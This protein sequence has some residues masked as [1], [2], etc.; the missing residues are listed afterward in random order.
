MADE[1]FRVHG[2][3]VD[4]ETGKGIPD[5]RVQALAE[6]LRPDDRLGVAITDAD[7]GFELVYERADFRQIYTDRKA[8]LYL[9]V[10]TADEETVFSSSDTVR[11]DSGV[12]MPFRI[13][14]PPAV[15]RKKVRGGE[16]RGGITVTVFNHR[17]RPLPKARVTLR[18]L[19]GREEDEI[20]LPYDPARRHF[21]APA[22][23]PGRYYLRAAAGNNDPDERE[24]VVG[25]NAQ[26]QTFVLGP[27]GLPILYR[28]KVR[29]PVKLPEDL[30][31][32]TLD[33]PKTDLRLLEEADRLSLK[34]VKIS[35]AIRRENVRVFRLRRGVSRTAR[36]TAQ[37]SLA[38]IPGVRLVG[39]VIK[40]T[41]RGVSYLTNELVVSFKS[42]VPDE[43][44]AAEFLADF[45]LI[46]VRTIPYANAFLARS[47]H[48]ADYELLEISKRIV[49]TGHVEYAEPH[50][51]IT[52][53]DHQVNPTDYQYPAQWTHA[54][55][56]LPAAWKLLET[57]LGA[58][59]TF[60]SPDVVIAVMDHGI[61]S[62]TVGGVA[63]AVHPDFSGTVSDG[64]SKVLTFF[65]FNNM[66][67][68]ND[69][70]D[71]MHGMGCAGIAA[72][73]PNNASPV[74]G[75]DEGIAGAAANCRVMAL[76]RPMGS[77]EVQ[78]ADAYAWAA[79]LDPG[80]TSHRGRYQPGT[81]FP[82]P[83][84][85][86]AD[87]I[88]SSF[89]TPHG[90]PINGLMDA[91]LIRLTSSGRGGHGCCLFFS[92][93]NDASAMDNQH[94]WASHASTMAVTAST[95]DATGK[96]VRPGYSNFG[97]AV[98]FCAPSSSS[99]GADRHNPP[100]AYG[101]ISTDFVGKGDLIGHPVTRTTLAAPSP[102]PVPRSNAVLTVVSAMGFTKQQRLQIRPPGTAGAESARVTH[103]DTVANKITVAELLN[104]HG[105]GTAV[106]TGPRDY[107]ANFGSTS[108]AAPL[109]AGVAALMLSV[110]PGLSWKRVRWI[111]KTT[112][113]HIDHT[114]LN[115][116]GKWIDTDGDGIVDHSQWYGC[117]RIDAAAAVQAAINRLGLPPV[118]GLDT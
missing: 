111:L 75:I 84:A 12:T 28:G 38:E 95:L 77:E 2:T 66:V 55:I 27:R 116:D 11:Y 118:P 22:P 53:E 50:L 105:F 54:L 112:A 52:M 74:A 83:P 69:A 117:G 58:S 68:N 61:Q 29:V 32:L 34:Q 59:R 42:S 64:T 49:D 31:A 96:E 1:R 65:D 114:Q 15:A 35:A 102:G 107:T 21:H 36:L 8:D 41:R 81:V 70:A 48:P 100:A 92:A 60:G 62:T 6:N 85:K 63:T 73:L 93:G 109:A 97:D 80:W 94:P 106:A 87:I 115:V 91:T 16:G 14:L 47:A 30:V 72:A 67:K 43:H 19:G 71:Y 110:N 90:F 101:A 3:I 113:E 9:R 108:A 4:R 44:A 37:Q 103:V 33:G 23:R 104:L 99:G 89:G 57:H 17:N 7:G 88:T 51:V 13:E 46:I 76:I 98:A 18:P 20:A 78:Y 45:G 24:I 39:P 79:G 26:A 82:A 10:K 56:G 86:G 5:L 40:L 25:P